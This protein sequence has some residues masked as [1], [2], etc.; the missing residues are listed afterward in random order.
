M[1]NSP[2]FVV[3]IEVLLLYIVKTQAIRL[4]LFMFYDFQVC[5]VFMFVCVLYIIVFI[6]EIIIYI[7]NVDDDDI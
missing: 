3:P 2:S 7:I 6:S 5:G 4:L 1:M